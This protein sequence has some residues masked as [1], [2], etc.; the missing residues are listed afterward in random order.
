[1]R[2]YLNQMR[3]V[4]QTKN[5]FK[6]VWR[7]LKTHCAA[8]ELREPP[9]CS[10]PVLIEMMN[11]Q[12][13]EFINL[14]TIKLKLRSGNYNSTLSIADDVTKMCQIYKRLLFEDSFKVNSINL[15][16]QYFNSMMGLYNIANQQLMIPP[17]PLS[18]SSIPEAVKEFNAPVHQAH[19]KQLS[20]KQANG[21]TPQ[22]N[23]QAAQL[24]SQLNNRNMKTQVRSD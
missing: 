22:S 16:E 14:R 18:P 23:A 13:F 8:S 6:I 20:P 9:D 15:F 10:K 17:E 12:G 24:V 4:Q 7:S 1:M 21:Q 5:A 19:A 3:D 2:L 11:E